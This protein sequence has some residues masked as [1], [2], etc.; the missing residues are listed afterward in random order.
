[1]KQ[2]NSEEE[3]L[4]AL[5]CPGSGKH[6][7]NSEHADTCSKKDN[8][9]PPLLLSIADD[10]DIQGDIL[11]EVELQACNPDF[12]VSYCKLGPSIKV[13]LKFERPLPRGSSEQTKCPA[14][15]KQLLIDNIVSSGN[16]GQNLC[17]S[18]CEYQKP[19]S[20]IIYSI[21]FGDISGVEPESAAVQ[22]KL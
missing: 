3:N 20:T 2:S 7:V 12:V 17:Q 13:G 15:K 22:S 11:H 9:E 10:S 1:M 5:K 6:Q 16:F 21:S 4:I 19:G 18:V 14:L 8:E